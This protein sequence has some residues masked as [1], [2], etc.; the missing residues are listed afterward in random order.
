MTSHY[1]FQLSLLLGVVILC[2]SAPAQESSQ[3]ITFH[4]YPDCLDLRNDTTRVV[5]CPV[6]G[7]RVLEYSLKGDNALYLEEAETGKPH[8]PNAPASITAGRFDIGPEKTIPSHPLLWSGKWTGELLGPRA[9]RLVSQQDQ[10]TGTQLVREFRLADSGSRLECQ[11]TIRNVSHEPTEWC[12]WSR[13]FARGNGICLIP[14]TSPSRFPNRYVMYEDG[15]RIN[16]RPTDPHIRTRDGFLEIFDVPRQP[17]LGMDSYA[18]WFAYLTRDNLLF[19]KRFPVYRDRV[20]N[21][22]AGLTISIWYPQDLRVELEPIGPRERLAPGE[23]ASF[24]EEWFLAPFP[25]PQQGEQVDLA[26]VRAV[27]T[28]T[29]DTR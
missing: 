16:I 14:L 9:A 27:V 8:D 28:E 3:V 19:I 12:H 21:E 23:S 17:K 25:F 18:G 29:L 20:Y 6:S 4:G 2:P 7:G 24:T 15:D 1:K 22:A 10:A 26:R 5:L 13:T 11:Q